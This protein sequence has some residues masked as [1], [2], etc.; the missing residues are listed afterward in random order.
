MTFPA[1]IFTGTR[2]RCSVFTLAVFMAGLIAAEA[3]A[4]ERKF[5]VMLAVPIKSLRA[6]TGEGNPIPQLPSSGDCFAHY[7][8]ETDPQINSYAEYWEEISYGQVHVSGDVFG[9]VEIPWPVLPLGD[10]EVDEGA[11]TISNLT[12]PFSDLNDND[13]YDQFAGE[14]VPE[15]QDQMIF[16]D[17]NGDLPGTATPGF[18]P[19]QNFR[20]PGLVDF[21]AQMNPVWTPGERFRDLDEDGRYDALLESTMDGWAT[22]RQ[23]TTIPACNNNGIISGEEICEMA[24][25]PLDGSFG[26]NDGTWDF[27][28]PFEDFLRIYDPTSPNPND[29]WIV[30]DPSPNNLFEGDALTVGSRVWAEE[31]IRRNYPGDADGLI[32]RCG[33]GIYDGPDQW[34]E[35]GQGRKLQ[36]QPGNARFAGLGSKRTPQ[37]DEP[38]PLILPLSYPRWSYATWWS[39]YWADKHQQAQMEAPPLPD[40]PAWP[41]VQ[42]AAGGGFAGNIPNM[43]FFDPEDPSLGELNNPDDLRTFLPNVGGTL[44]RTGIRCFDGA[45]N[46]PSERPEPSETGRC[47]FTDGGLQC[48]DGVSFLECR[49]VFEGIWGE[50]ESCEDPIDPGC[51]TPP[52][53]VPLCFQDP[54]NVPPLDEDPDASLC[55]SWPVP[56]SA[57]GGHLG[58]YDGFECEQC[59]VTIT[60][61]VDPASLGDGSI[62]FRNSGADQTY[63]QKPV[64]PDELDVDGDGAPDYYDGGAEFDDLPSSRYHAQ[65]ILSGLGG[66]GDL[67]FGEVTSIRDFE[68]EEG[69]EM[70]VYMGDDVGTGDPSGAG[71]PD[72]VIP[73]GGPLA[74]RVHGANGYDGGNVLTIE[75]LTWRRDEPTSPAMKRDFNLDGLLDLGEIRDL[76]TEN[77]AIDLDGGT[78]NDGGPQGSTYPFNR[79][80][81]LEDTVAALDPSVDWD[82]VVSKVAQKITAQL[83]GIGALGNFLAGVDLPT[84][85]VVGVDGVSGLSNVI[86]ENIGFT[87]VRGADA[88]ILDVG[89][90]DARPALFAVDAA[91][92][93]L[94]LVDFLNAGPCG[95]DCP[96]ANG[97]ASNCC[98]AHGTGGCDDA[99]CQTCVCGEDPFCC[100]VEWDGL[101]VGL[102]STG[103]Q[104]LGVNGDLTNVRGLAFDFFQ[105]RLFGVTLD[106]DRLVSI[107]PANGATTD[108]GTGVGFSQI[109]GLGYDPNLDVLYG[110]DANTNQLIRINVTTGVG[111]AVGPFGQPFNDI[112]GLS[113]DIGSNI[114]YGTNIGSTATLV[115]INTNTGK[116]SPVV[117][118]FLFSTVLLPSGLYQDGLAPGGRGLFQLPAP[119]MD[120]PINIFEDTE[121]GLSPIF[122]SDFTTAL[123]GTGEMGDPANE[124]TF[125]KEL[126]AHEF[127]H[128]W[129]GYPDLYDYDV[130]IGGIENRP[131]GVW[132]IMAGGFVHPSPFLKEFGTGDPRIGTDHVPWIQTADLREHLSPLEESEITLPDFAFEPTDSAFYYENEN[133]AGERFYFWRLTRK[134]YD[135]PEWINFSRSLPG[136]GFM[137]MHTDFGGNFGGF[138]GNFEGFPLQQRIGGHAAYQIVQADGLKQLEDGSSFGDAGDPFPGTSGRTTMSDNGAISPSTAWYNVGGSNTRSG[139]IM[140]NVQTFDEFSRVTF[141]WNPRVLPS[142]VFL[143]PPGGFVVGGNYLIRYEA[144][145]FFGGTRIEFYW[146]K[147]TVHGDGFATNAEKQIIPPPPQANPATKPPSVVTQTFPLPLNQLSDGEYFLYARLIPGT[148]SD[149]S[150]EPAFS[151][152]FAD[153]SN[154]GRGHLESVSVNVAL[155]KLEA[156]TLL[157]V[158]DATAG[159]ELWSVEGSLSGMQVGQATTGAPFTTDDGGVTFTIVSDAIVGSGAETSN[160]GGE[161]VLDDPNADFD[162]TSFREGNTVRILNGPNPGFYT[163]LQVPERTRL[164]LGSDPGN[165]SGINYRVHSFADDNDIDPDRL[166]FLTTG[167]TQHSLPIQV[168][169][170]QVCPQ[171]FPDVQVTFVDGVD[172]TGTNPNNRVPLRVFFDATGTRD[173]LG[174]Q[175]PN[176]QY[177]WNFGDG[178][179]SNEAQVLKTFLTEGNF[180]VTL[181]VTNP[182]AAIPPAGCPAIIGVETIDIIVNPPDADEDGVSDAVD[183]CLGIFNPGQEDPDNDGLGSACD[184]CPDDFNPDQEDFDNDDI[185]DPCDPDFDGDGIP[186]E[187]FPGPCVGGNTVACNDNCPGIPNPTQAD[188]DSDGVADAC[189]NCPSHANSTQADGDGDGVG[190]ACDNCPANFNPGQGDSDGDGL[191]DTCD[192]C[193]FAANPNQEDSDQDGIPNA[194]DNCAG[195]PNFNQL[196]FDNDDFGDVCDGC[197]SDPGK[198]LPGICGCGTPDID[199]DG[200]GEPDCLIFAPPV[201]D[202]DGDGTKDDVDG[203]PD[204]PTKVT[205]GACGCNVPETDSDA[206]GVAD[207]IDNC[208]NVANPDQ[209]DSNG[210][211][212]GDACD[213]TTGGTDPNNPPPAGNLCPFFGGVASMPFTLLGIGLLKR[214]TRRS[215]RK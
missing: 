191:G 184:N 181:T 117:V 46:Q 167:R 102:T 1:S 39:A 82:P 90:D 22:P 149:G 144:F 212:I 78:P 140:R 214:R 86:A 152:V 30:L 99:G 168:L 119:A 159:A 188:Q 85:D 193:P 81:I 56:P 136:D 36:Q 9:W 42:N 58:T 13:T 142:L 166:R 165:A 71:G 70:L 150:P 133:N 94:L 8:D 67:L 128:V 211:F 98:S 195:I 96:C 127:L 110:A 92:G 116:A 125:G 143:N 6:A 80:R 24:E 157:C 124:E 146:D 25:P 160:A 5:V 163:I 4:Q 199:A 130:Y 89:T 37:P 172:G 194:C 198:V 147:N 40:P 107:D 122:F 21:D 141:F 139:L 10:F 16:I 215:R 31:Y 32:A 95:G 97:G 51:A 84:A 196:D 135:N 108:I 68:L 151:D 2:R 63:L 29:R 61:C 209:A 164:I 138:A 103:V 126:M 208:P 176:L 137:F 60:L 154:D 59:F 112:R 183:N 185:G 106:D 38:S 177:T 170:G 69:E 174:F 7:F 109:E 47:C 62:D 66:G 77:Y 213:P 182:N 75:W 65:G 175:N 156:W 197:P 114:L 145:D 129:E 28:E 34:T 45:V 12:L 203:C 173:E 87:D 74:F 41:P 171:L 178:T 153:R 113:F 162:A 134:D 180:T 206:D 148:G 17:Y 15:Q 190:N 120:L 26:D 118:N 205:P 88:T 55:G 115:T 200:D 52:G 83:E 104:V 72:D 48:V 132:D 100:D 79:R 18:P 73:A 210:N 49:D 105:N 204:D 123:G 27:P 35:S 202:S 93:S 169:N 131:V 20:T 3:Q 91:T 50:N 44:A 23:G 53:D 57:A 192:L 11:T 207:C 101:C 19:D 158:D 64:L 54:E 189:D 33:N 155:S 186:E 76:G 187:G 43:R 179:S 201:P 14:A 161:F 121:D 111:T